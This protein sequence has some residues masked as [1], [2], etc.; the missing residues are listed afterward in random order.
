MNIISKL[1]RTDKPETIDEVL[2]NDL[3]KAVVD[4]FIREEMQDAT[5]VIIIWEKRSGDKK[6]TFWDHGGME[7]AQAILTLDQ[8]HHRIQH[9]GLQGYD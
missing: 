7:P 1:L 4:K 8:L 6:Q 5:S 9:E 2:K 3:V